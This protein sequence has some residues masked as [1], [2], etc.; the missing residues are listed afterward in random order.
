MTRSLGILLESGGHA[1]GHYALV[2]AAGAAALGREV[3]LFA[4]NQGCLLL[5]EPCPLL[6]DPREAQV[7][8]AGVAGVGTLL[9]ACAE[10]GVR[11]IVCEAGLKAEGLTGLTL[12]A[13][14]EVAGIATF[15][16]AVGDGQ[17]V[18]L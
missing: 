5:A 3:T 9:E 14:V 10:L 11:R 4:T 7:T 1:R 16:D 15:L 13:G 12:A 17:I 6:D 18:T 2:V 8:A